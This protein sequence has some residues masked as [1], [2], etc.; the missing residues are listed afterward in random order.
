M[1]RKLLLICGIGSSVLYAAMNVFVAMAWEGYSSK[2]QTVSELSAVDAPTRALWVPL[3]IVYTLLVAAFGWG[4]RAIATA[5]RSLRIA[6]SFLV[7]YGITGLAWPLFPMHLRK[8]LAAGGATWT[9]PMHIAFTSVTV[10]LMVLA[11]GFGAAGLGRPFRI[12]SIVTIVALFTFGVL[13]GRE[14]PGID[15]NGSTPW[16]GVYERIIIGVYLVWVAVLAIVLLRTA[17]AREQSRAL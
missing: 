4:V 5:N 14:A 12:Y 8:V 15:V 9:D 7:A 16:I 3:G 17:D 13:T 1:N 2:T 6:G 11:M 10:L